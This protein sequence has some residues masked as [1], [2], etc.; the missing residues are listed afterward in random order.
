M[1]NL[2]SIGLPG[3]DGE[4]DVSAAHVPIRLSAWYISTCQLPIDI[5]ICHFLI[6]VLRSTII[7]L[8]N[9]IVK[10]FRICNHVP[11][12]LPQKEINK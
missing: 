5:Y 11:L 4:E 9:I 12:Q 7:Y 6:T 10:F 1:A 2:L 8:N 3:F